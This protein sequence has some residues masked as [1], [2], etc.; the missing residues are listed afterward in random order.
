MD[1]IKTVG[2][3]R[4][5]LIGVTHIRIGALTF[6]YTDEKDIDVKFQEELI[7]WWPAAVGD[8]VLLSSEEDAKSTETLADLKGDARKVTKDLLAAN[9]KIE[10]LEKSGGLVNQLG[11]RA[12]G[13]VEAYEKLL[14]GR[15]VVLE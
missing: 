2:D 12:M 3:L 11:E 5:Y 9:E 13:K 1:N 8:E 6:Y 15:R 10:E 7:M 4:K 14:I